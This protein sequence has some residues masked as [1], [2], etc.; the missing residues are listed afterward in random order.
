MT[1]KKRFLK[2]IAKQRGITEKQLVY[3]A[4]RDGGN[5]NRAAELLGVP[6]TSITNAMAKYGMMVEFTTVIRVMDALPS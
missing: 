6:R 2:D 5:P 1:K 3:E 4:L